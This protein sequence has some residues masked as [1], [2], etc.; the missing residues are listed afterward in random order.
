R[1]SLRLWG[2]RVPCGDGEDVVQ[3]SEESVSESKDKNPFELDVRYRYDFD[4]LNFVSET[5]ALQNKRDHRYEKLSLKRREILSKAEHVCYVNSK[6][7]NEAVLECGSI[8]LQTLMLL[9]PL[10]FLGIGLAVLWVGF[11]ANRSKGLAVKTMR[12]WRLPPFRRTPRHRMRW[13]AG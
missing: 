10:P 2:L 1:T 3:G 11:R 4:G 6:E 13:G 5:F 7:P 9:L 12:R 8:R